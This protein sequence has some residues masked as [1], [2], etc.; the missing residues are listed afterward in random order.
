MYFQDEMYKIKHYNI[1]VTEV[2]QKLSI[3]YSNNPKGN[4]N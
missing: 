2:T 3:H 1:T 4:I